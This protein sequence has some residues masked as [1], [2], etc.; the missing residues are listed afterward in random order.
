[1]D[2]TC[3]GA[4]EK[5]NGNKGRSRQEE[6]LCAVF[7]PSQIPSEAGSGVWSKGAKLNRGDEG[8]V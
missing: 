3:A 5:H 8:E 4:G 2:K 7:I 6:L 1:M